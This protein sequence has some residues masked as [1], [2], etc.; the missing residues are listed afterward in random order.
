M[1]WDAVG[2]FGMLWDAS[3]CLYGIQED[4]KNFSRVLLWN[5]MGFYKILRDSLKW[6]GILR[7]LWDSC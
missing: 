2:C 1:L 5:A 4:F 6:F 3:G 7:M